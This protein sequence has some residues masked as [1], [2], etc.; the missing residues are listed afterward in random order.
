MI[1]KKGGS[2]GVS[3]NKTPGTSSSHPSMPSG[4]TSTANCSGG[5]GCQYSQYACRECYTSLSFM[6]LGSAGLPSTMNDPHPRVDF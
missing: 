2:V 4:E 6:G 3:G 5:R 1:I